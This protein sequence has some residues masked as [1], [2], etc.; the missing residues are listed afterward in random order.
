MSKVTRVKMARG[1]KL[2]TEHVFPTLQQAE[3]AMTSADVEASQRAANMAPFRVN[4]SIPRVSGAMCAVEGSEPGYSVHHGIPFMLP[5]LQEHMSFTTD[6]RFG[7]TAEPAE[8]APVIILDEV[9]FSFDQRAEPAAIVGSLDGTAAPPYAEQGRIAYDQ[10]GSLNIRLFIMEKRPVWFDVPGTGDKFNPERAVW[11][12][13]IESGRLSDGFLRLNPWVSSG[14]NEV[15]DPYK[16]YLFVIDAPSLWS[17][18]T[19]VTKDLAL[20]GVE[21][22]MRFLAQTVDRD[23]GASVQNIPQRHLGVANA[24]LTHATANTTGAGKRSATARPLIATPPIAGDT[25][26]PNTAN[27]VQT[28][29]AVVDEMM[30]RK[31]QGG[32]ALNS[33]LPILEEMADSAAYSVIAVPLFNNTRWGGVLAG[34]FNNEP[35]ITGAAGERVIDRRYIPI[36][37]PMTIHHVLYTYNWQAFVWHNPAVPRFENTPLLPAGVGA[38]TPDLEVPIGVGIGP[39][40]RADNYGYQ[41]VASASINGGLPSALTWAQN[42][43][44]QIA[45]GAFQTLPNI[46]IAAGT[47]LGWNVELHAANIIGTGSPGLNGMTAQGAP[48]FVGRATTATEDRTDVDAGPSAPSAVNGEEQWIEVRGSIGDA[49][50]AVAIQGGYDP[51]SMVL[52][53]GGLWVYI[54]GKTHQV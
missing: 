41:Q 43:V 10:T 30:R 37:T 46:N 4:L 40:N 42:V 22:S 1:A 15:I 8:G 50:A 24:N 21:I 7:K 39:G 31:L 13:T 28:S 11:T 14:I 2:L 54:I 9:T 26:E 17:G 3:S 18:A 49:N 19:S 38:V 12:G 5:P 53:G 36:E 52:G 27:G 45:N 47:R 48:F 51:A 16:S 34:D 32:Y 33:D 44:D 35:Y 6:A 20:N 25:I 23:S 29:M